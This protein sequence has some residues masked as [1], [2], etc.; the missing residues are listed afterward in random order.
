MS[1]CCLLKNALLVSVLG[2]GHVGCDARGVSL[3]TEEL[4]VADARLSLASGQLR[5]SELSTCS[6]IGDNRLADSGFET[7][8]VGDCEAGLYCQFSA[9]DVQGWHTSSEA[10][11]IEI[12]HDMHLKIPAP[13]GSQFV[14]LDAQSPDSLWQD[15]ALRPGQLMYWSLLHRGRNGAESMELMIGPPEATQS[16]G[17]LTSDAAAWYPYDGLYRVGEMETLTRFA[18]ESRTGLAEGNLVDAVVFAPVE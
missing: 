2:I 3:G 13:E 18:L 12:W 11:V 7:P 6:R 14:E 5:D 15:V 16:Q 4:C 9:A 17:V 1:P 10:Q 8:V